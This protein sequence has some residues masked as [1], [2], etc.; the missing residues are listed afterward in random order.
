MSLIELTAILNR[1][2]TPHE[3]KDASAWAAIEEQ[4]GTKLPQDYKDFIQTFGSGAIDSFLY[5]F[6]P[7][8]PNKNINLIEGGRAELEA[9]SISKKKFPQYYRHEA[10][11]SEGGILP[12][13]ATD[14]GEI[15]YWKTA[16]VP[17]RW[18]VIAY[19]ARGPKYYEFEGSTTEFL[20]GVLKRTIRCDV[21]P[22][23]FPSEYPVF[24]P[25]VS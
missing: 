25:T 18:T 20:T 21:F 17:E 6:N 4:V 5:V 12:F 19:E 11:P 24:K 22:D 8:S 7:F 13:A 10:Y 9:Y 1:P 3:T 2:L 14:N 15:I 23:D 16:R